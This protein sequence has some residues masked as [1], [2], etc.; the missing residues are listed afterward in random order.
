MTAIILA[1]GKSKRMNSFISKVLLPLYGRPMLWYILST[2]KR[3]RPNRILVVV[4]RNGDE[5]RNQFKKEKIEFVEQPQPLGTADA[6]LR[7]KDYLKNPGEDVVIL[8]G[9]VPLLSEKTLKNLVE[10]YY[11]EKADAVL[12]TAEVENPKGYGRIVRRETGEVDRIVEEKEAAEEIKRIKEINS[13]IYVFKAKP[14]L[15]A[16]KKIRPS[17]KI[18]EYYLT[19]TIAEIIRD[20][21]KVISVITPDPIEIRGVNTPEELA[22]IK[23][24]MKERWGFSKD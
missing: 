11:K 4:G 21:G 8:C 19:D 17:E 18:G 23:E 5:I 10:T 2:T 13:G 6:V 12:L 3:L 16:L 15:E 14:L 7:C 24:A 1:A 22:F 20:R 9:D